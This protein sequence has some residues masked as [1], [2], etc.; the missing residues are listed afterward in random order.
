VVGRVDA[1]NTSDDDVRSGHI[2]CVLL[3]VSEARGHT[4]EPFGDAFREI[5]ER[6]RTR[7]IA[8][9]RATDRVF[10][11][12]KEASRVRQRPSIRRAAPRSQRSPTLSPE[13]V[14]AR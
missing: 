12:L 4:I 13:S 10:A 3:G 2:S 11:L 5:Y 14:T 8:P 6:V 7:E 9:E 1:D